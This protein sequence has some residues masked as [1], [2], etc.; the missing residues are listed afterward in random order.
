[1]EIAG[2]E[3]PR[4][5]HGRSLFE[6]HPERE[7]IFAARDRCDGTVDRIR[8]VR[9]R[10]F[11]YIRNF[12]PE[13]P[14]AQFNAYKKLQYPVLTLMEVLDDRGELDPG[15]SH[16][17]EPRRPEEELYDISNDPHEIDNLASDPDFIE[18]LANLRGRLDEWIADTGDRGGI[19]EDDK[20][21]SYWREHME[22]GFAEK[23]RSRGL[24]PDVSGEDYLHWWVERLGEM[25]GNKPTI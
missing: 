16:F 24:E 11:K 8:C 25:K 13:R 20:V 3:V 5:F 21:L 6:I 18:I 10:R 2:L 12:L 7:C 14:Y 22:S 19:P 23:M 1:M 4:Y 17:L 15:Q 9:T